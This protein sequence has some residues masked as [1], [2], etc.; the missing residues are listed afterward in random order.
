LERDISLHNRIASLRFVQLKH[1]D[2]KP[3]MVDEQQ[4][5]SAVEQ[6]LHINSVKSP[7]GK[8]RC[9]INCAKLIFQNLTQHCKRT[10]GVEEFL[11]GKFG[12]E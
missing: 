1:L 8:L 12:V 5:D 3:G 11:P 6:L 4:L 9:I 7:R 2:V 10:P